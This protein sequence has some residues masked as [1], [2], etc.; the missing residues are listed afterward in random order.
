MAL[1]DCR[2]TEV[3]TYPYGYI[4]HVRSDS[5]PDEWMSHVPSSNLQGVQE[6]DVGWVRP[7]RPAGDEG[8][9]QV[10]A[11]HMHCG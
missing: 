1:A 7:A 3:R 2:V 5:L 11:L 4:E 6:D 9:A 8:R 10:G